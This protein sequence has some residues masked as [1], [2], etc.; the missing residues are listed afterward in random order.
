[1]P[2]IPRKFIDNYVDALARISGDNGVVRDELRKALERIDWTQSVAAI[3]DQLIDVMQVY[4]GGATDQSA[5]LAAEFYDG[6]REQVV[7][8]QF[9]AFAYSGREPAATDE[10]IRAFVQDL[11]DG[12][13]SKPVIDK[14]LERLD[15]ETRKAAAVCVTHN[16]N[17]DPNRP[18]Y[19]RVPAGGETCDFCIMLASR[20]PVY[21]SA[22][23]AG[24]VDHFHAN[25]RCQVVPMFNTYQT[26]PSRRA[27][28]SMSIEGYDP[29]ALYEQY[30][31]QM[32]DPKFRERV[33]SGAYRARGASRTAT[34]H[35]TSH[36]LVWANAKKEGRVTFGSVGEITESIKAVDTYEEL[37]ELIGTLSAEWD[38][39]ALSEQYRLAI[40]KALRDRRKELI[41]DNQP[42]M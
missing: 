39:Y 12:R 27:S 34:G 1:M 42:V 37:F 32:L 36:P 19:A 7:G 29:D 10:A 21:R 13:G 3:R 33:A 28:A 23:S 2:T 8:E 17:R 35:D 18:R 40:Q 31:Q 26:G 6:L 41:S 15:Y 24:A 38:D 14:C 9:G 22:R 16:A 25:C 30:V 4:C 11:V 20:G 5:M